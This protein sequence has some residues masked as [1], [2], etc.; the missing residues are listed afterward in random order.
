MLT[1]NAVIACGEVYRGIFAP[2]I[3]SDRN[4]FCPA[5]FMVDSNVL[6]FPAYRK[7]TGQ[8]AA[9]VVATEPTGTLPPW[10]VNAAGIKAGA[11]L[12]EAAFSAKE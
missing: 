6:D 8:D 11:V 10:Q 1:G 7:V 12:D 3:R 9:S 2:A 4:Y 5:K